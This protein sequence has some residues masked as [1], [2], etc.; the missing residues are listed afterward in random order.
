[1]IELIIRMMAERRRREGVNE[2]NEANASHNAGTYRQCGVIERSTRTMLAVVA[3]NQ[4]LKG[5]PTGN[6]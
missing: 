3:V 6:A 5:C 1:M 2:S 4:A